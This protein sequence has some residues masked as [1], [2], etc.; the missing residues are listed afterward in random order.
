MRIN[1]KLTKI[2]FFLTLS[3]TLV[4]A[5]FFLAVKFFFPESLTIEAG[6]ENMLLFNIPLSAKIMPNAVE[7]LSVNQKSVTDNINVSLSDPVYLQSKDVGE[8]NVE[9]SLFGLLTIKNVTVNVLP[10]TYLI[11]S[12]MAVGVKVKTDGIMVLGTGV[13][14]AESGS[15]EP[16]KS[17][18]KSGDMILSANSKTMKTKADFIKLVEESDGNPIS[19]LINRDGQEIKETI[20]PIKCTDDE[21]YKIGI[22]IRDS[23]GGIGTMTYYNP[24]TQFFGALGHG[25]LD[26]DTKLLMK[27]KE[28]S[29][30]HSN[31]TSVKKGKKGGP[32]ELVGL[33]LDDEVIGSVLKNTKY[34]IYGKIDNSQKEAFEKLSKPY[35]IALKQDVHEGRAT[36]LCTV[37][38][39]DIKEYDVFVESVN[40]FSTDDAKGMIIR[41]VDED[42]VEA[43]GGIVQGMSGSPILQDGKIIG[44]VTHVFVQDPTKGYGIFIENM[45]RQEKGES[46]DSSFLSLSCIS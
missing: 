1:S 21:V 38:G 16:A 23:T 30:S 25:I 18:I 36:I 17:I 37:N 2:I 3:V 41:I 35:P 12:G 10:E 27:I 33:I 43:T 5:T 24:E 15:V 8:F 4:L 28:G 20:T 34:G 26:V 31:L 42:L 11:P 14:R 22:W 13:V 19:I 9:L 29:I 45:L 6:R 39:Q 46:T 40:R 7:V 32:G 44:A